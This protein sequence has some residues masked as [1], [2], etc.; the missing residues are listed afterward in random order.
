M[1]TFMRTIIEL[2]SDQ[3]EAL[4]ALCRRDGISRAEAI[5][6]AVADHVRRER[7]PDVDRVFGL[8]RTRHV[9]GIK[10]QQRLRREWDRR[11]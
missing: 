2:P 6:R 8:W 5:R 7:A 3:I 11:S 4:D 1:M 10:Y 9:D